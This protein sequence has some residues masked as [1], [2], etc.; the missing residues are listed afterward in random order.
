MMVKIFIVN[1]VLLKIFAT[2]SYTHLYYVSVVV[3]ENDIY[4]KLTPRKIIGI[5]LG[6]KDI[7]STSE[8]VYKRQQ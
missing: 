6:I 2:V 1:F 7:I 4:T 3:E 8:D 5:D